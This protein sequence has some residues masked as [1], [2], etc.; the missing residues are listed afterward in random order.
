MSTVNTKEYIWLCCVLSCTV[1]IV[2]YDSILSQEVI[3]RCATD[4]LLTDANIMEVSI[5]R[6][7]SHEHHQ[8]TAVKKTLPP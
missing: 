5:F 7:K 3:L 6:P 4:G 2:T 1:S 8:L